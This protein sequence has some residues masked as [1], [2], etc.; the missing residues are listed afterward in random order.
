MYMEPCNVI[1]LSYSSY[2]HYAVLCEL[3]PAGFPSLAVCL[4]TITKGLAY[5]CLNK[6][7]SVIFGFLRMFLIY[8]IRIFCV[9]E[10]SDCC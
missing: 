1:L 7:D 3:L 10:V 2:D 9:Y 4:L 6:R 8:N 5:M